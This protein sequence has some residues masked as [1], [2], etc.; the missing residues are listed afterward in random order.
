KPA[1]MIVSPPGW[2]QE[3]GSVALWGNATLQSKVYLDK[4]PA[5][6]T[7]RALGHE[8]SGQW[9]AIRVELDARPLSTLVIN[10]GSPR[11][12]ALAT[13][14]EKTGTAVLRLVFENH[15]PG[16]TPIEGRNL[17]VQL[18]TITQDAA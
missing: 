13:T 10:S 18:V 16:P 3:D 11:D 15:A 12:F 7:V 2:P 1:A 9:P 4:G 5:T 6:I 8:T 14:V 17:R